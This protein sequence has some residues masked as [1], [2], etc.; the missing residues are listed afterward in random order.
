MLK[1]GVK[2]REKK[3]GA[4]GIRTRDLWINKNTRSHS[5]TANGK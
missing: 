4:A 3:L 1:K 5:A 2:K